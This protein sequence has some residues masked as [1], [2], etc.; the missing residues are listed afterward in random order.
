MNKA[1]FLDRDGVINK[2][3]FNSKTGE[4]ESPHYVED[5]ELYS[6]TLRSLRELREMGYLLFLV[7]NQPSFAKGKTSIENIRAIHDKLHRYFL[8]YHI[9]FAEYYYCYHHPDGMVPELTVECQCRKPSNL[10]LAMAYDKYQFSIQSSWLIG[11]Q[12][13]DIFC[14]QSF[15]LRTILVDE[16]GSC[17]KRGASLPDFKAEN[18]EDAVKIISEN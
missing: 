2:L 8:D 15:G 5:L 18:L 17:N 6:W 1:V 10:F 13:S 16:N 14:G 7:S 4:Y 9:D 12:D 3:V 11:D